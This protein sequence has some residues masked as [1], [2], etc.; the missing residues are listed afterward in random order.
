MKGRLVLDEE[1]TIVQV[2]K[3]RTRSEKTDTKGCGQ[4]TRLM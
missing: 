1:I 3:A 2:R 4:A